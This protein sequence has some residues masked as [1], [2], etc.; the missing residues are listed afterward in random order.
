MLALAL[1]SAGPSLIPGAVAP[2]V[3]PDMMGGLPPA[4][5]R[6]IAPNLGIYFGQ[7]GDFVTG[8]N[9]PATNEAEPSMVNILPPRGDRAFEMQDSPWDNELLLRRT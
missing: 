9:P 7:K 3:G 6:A 8:V 1:S 5:T 4:V 2:L